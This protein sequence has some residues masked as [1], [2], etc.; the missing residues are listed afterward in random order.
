MLAFVLIALGV[1]ES[2]PAGPQ[3]CEASPLFDGGFENGLGEWVNLQALPGRATLRHGRSFCGDSHARFEVLPGDVEPETEDNRAELTGPAYAQGDDLWYRQATRLGDGFPDE[4]GEFQIV[5]QWRSGDGSP[6]VAL[7]VEDGNS[8]VLRRGDEPFTEFW[9]GPGYTGVWIDLIVHIRFS[10]RPSEG[11][12]EV[13]RDGR[14]QTMENGRE[15]MYGQT[16]KDDTGNVKV[17]YYRSQGHEG[18]GVV[19]HDNF[20][21]G[22]SL[23]DVAPSL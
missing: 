15:R 20:L 21:V 12:V 9:R 22:R 6:P 4:E 8:L 1:G 23:S 19:S 17:G 5:S 18:A 13:W 16:I 10:E 2:T 3:R 11:F 7:F 14:R